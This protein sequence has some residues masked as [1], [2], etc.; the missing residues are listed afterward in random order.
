MSPEHTATLLKEFPKIFPRPPGR[1]EDRWCFEC[2]D[3]WYELLYKLCK[4]LQKVI[5][6]E[7]LPQVVASQVKEKFGT[8]RFYHCGGNG[9]TK[10]LIEVAEDMAEAICEVCGDPARLRQKKGSWMQTLCEKHAH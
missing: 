6:T 3:G 4:D 10:S 1:M 9:Q 7:N 8:L 5:D 2:G